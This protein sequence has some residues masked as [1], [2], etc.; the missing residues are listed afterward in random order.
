MRAGGGGLRPA[1]ALF[2]PATDAAWSCCSGRASTARSAAPKAGLNR[3]D[4]G[5]HYN[6][7]ISGGVFSRLLSATWARSPATAVRHHGREVVHTS[8]RDH[9][10][11]NDRVTP[12]G[13]E[14]GSL[15][16]R[17]RVQR[18]SA[19]RARRGCVASASVG[20]QRFVVRRIAQDLCAPLASARQQRAEPASAPPWGP[21]RPP[22]RRPSRRRR[23]CGTP[24]RLAASGPRMASRSRR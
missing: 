15:L 10:R 2:W 21:V 4:L 17:P 14:P 18:S 23:T 12:S 22:R 19:K 8:K 3:S 6:E 1:R 11:A 7:T 16:G 9:G 13:T 24:R 5:R 20:W